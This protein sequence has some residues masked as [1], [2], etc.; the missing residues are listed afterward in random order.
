MQPISHTFN[1]LLM[2][3]MWPFAPFSVDWKRLPGNLLL[4]GWTYRVGHRCQQRSPLDSFKFCPALSLRKYEHQPR[5]SIWTMGKRSWKRR[6]WTGGSPKAACKPCSH[7]DTKER[8]WLLQPAPTKLNGRYSQRISISAR[9]KDCVGW[10][11][12]RSAEGM[13]CFGQPHAKTYE[14]LALWAFGDGK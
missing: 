4:P 10:K 3:A 9:G 8:L 2:I 1:K 7:R 13:Q 6:A 14:H 5:L 11:P 12:A